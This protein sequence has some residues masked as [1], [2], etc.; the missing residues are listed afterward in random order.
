MP[1]S[2][3]EKEFVEYVVDLMQS[4][5]Q[6][7]AKRMFGGHGLFLDDLMFALIADN[8][9]YFKADDKTRIDF[10]ERELEPFTYYKQGKPFHLSYYQAPEETLEEADAM[11][12][13]AGRAFTVALRANKR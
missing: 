7:H 9:L 6:V 4:I 3:E 5:G 13:W 2:P 1:V 12:H 10:T 8:E 11:Q